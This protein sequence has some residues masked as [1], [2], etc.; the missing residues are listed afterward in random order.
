MAA[1]N[2]NME[3]WQE[4]SGRAKMISLGWDGVRSSYAKEGQVGDC[5]IVYNWASWIEGDD[6]HN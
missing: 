1:S 4:D 2:A 3:P 5:T 6:N